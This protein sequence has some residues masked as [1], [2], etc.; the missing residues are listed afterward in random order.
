MLDDIDSG[1][2]GITEEAVS[3]R[4]RRGT[5]AD[6]LER[7]ERAQFTEPIPASTQERTGFLLGKL[8]D[9]TKALAARLG[10][11]QR[12]VQRY[13]AGTVT[14][15]R[16]AARE[17]LEDETCEHWQQDVRTEARQRAA[18]T[19][20]TISTRATFGFDAGAG[21]SDSPRPR[22]LTQR[23]SGAHAGAIIAAR[24]A[25]ATDDQLTEMVGEALADAYFRIEGTGT[26]DL[27]V[28]LR[29][30]DYIDMSF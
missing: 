16:A 8:K 25:G 28:H 26:A 21:T 2:D 6:G 3:G 12:T 4:A 23:I 11:S 5:I 13:R 18:S 20:F 29:D 7:A 10:V 1:I 24:E 14:R 19:G 9:G 30:I 15:P 27:K 22:L 17:A